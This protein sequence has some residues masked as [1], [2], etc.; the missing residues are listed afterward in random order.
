MAIANLV[1]GSVPGLSTEAVRIVD[2][3]GRLLSQTDGQNSDR[4]ELQARMEEKL[5]AQVEQLL[6][7]MIGAENFSTEIQADLDMDEVTSA[8]ESYDKDGA[9]R[10]ETVQES[11]SSSAPTAAGVPGAMSNTPPTDA[12]AEA[13]APNPGRAAATAG[14]SNDNTSSSRTYEL[15]R[16]V[17]VSNIA[18][19]GLKRLSVAVAL[20]EEAMK[21]AKPE[22]LE[23]IK[24]LVSA[25]VGAD[26]KRGDTVAVMVRPFQT[27]EV[28]ALPFWETAWFATVLRNAVA[29]ISVLLVLLLVV[30]PAMKALTR[31][32]GKSA[33]DGAAAQQG[34]TNLVPQQQIGGQAPAPQQG[35]SNQ[36]LTSQIELA[37]RIVREKPDDALEAL[38]RMLGEAEQAEG[39]R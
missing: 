8:R 9:V 16:E 6:A 22:E 36:Q 1:S 17:A 3:H 10:R 28:E 14:P 24:E 34:V 19:G 37:Q 25:A 32:R 12:Q 20:N 5:R 4:L 13:G 23:K 21:G 15:G 2:Q 7:P 27:V 38:R 35:S 18:P 31:N 29:L 30:R 26:E 39:A 11:T 33:G